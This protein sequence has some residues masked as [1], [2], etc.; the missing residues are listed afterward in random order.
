MADQ[1]RLRGG[2]KPAQEMFTG[3][4]REISVD[5]DLNTIRVHDGVTP[6]GHLL[7][8]AGTCLQVSDPGEPCAVNIDGDLTVG[9]DVIF[10]GSLTVPD[11]VVNLESDDIDLTNP[12]T[13]NAHCNVASGTVSTQEDANKWF[14]EGVNTLDEKLCVAQA[15][16]VVLEKQYQD[17]QVRVSV[18]E[19]E[20]GK[21][22]TEIANLKQEI[23]DI[24]S[25]IKLL[26]IEIE[27]NEIAIN[28]NA[29]AIGKLE[30][31]VKAIFL[32]LVRLENLIKNLELNDL[33]DVNAP[34]PTDGQQLVYRG[35]KW[36]AED[37]PFVNQAVHFKG[38]IDTQT[39]AAPA[40]DA[41]DTYIQ[42]R[43][44][45][46]DA[47]A[48]ASWNGI[49]GE[50][51]N[52]GQY[53]MYGVDGLWHKGKT[54]EDV[55]QIQ[56]DWNEGD[57]SSPGYIA[58]KPDI[59]GMIDTSLLDPN[60]VGRG[61]INVDAG[62]G[63]TAAGSNAT[64]NQSGNTTRTLSVSNGAGLTFDANGKL[65]I[66]PNYNLDGNVTAP[67]NGTLTIKDSIGAIVGTFTANQAT[68]SEVSL[69]QGFSGSYNDLTD[70]PTE[71]PPIAHTHNY[72]PL[73]IRTLQELS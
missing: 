64:A 25:A 44:D 29:V 58:N 65:I 41:G 3:A 53:V 13:Y 26:E 66:D 59:Q 67:N 50:T 2:S 22:Q 69:P 48:I 32:E 71:F 68:N 60:K 8:R 55:T 35:D 36:V 12:G 14:Y 37:D 51:V 18:N 34:A 21:L 4:S 62:Q 27:A 43:A 11:L 56:S 30:E 45:G 46:A 28:D 1:L 42:S 39:D 24:E 5:T 9:G 72:M 10:E 16:L 47:I 23:V 31:D 15:E 52:E 17:L 38:F 20:I 57:V 6:G 49:A 61:Q 33:A 70:V 40:A 63:L 19:V 7:M 73:D 54:V